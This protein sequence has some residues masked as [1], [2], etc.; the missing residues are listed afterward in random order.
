MNSI[1][2]TLNSSYSVSN[3]IWDIATSCVYSLVGMILLYAT[4]KSLVFLLESTRDIYNE[5]KEVRSITLPFKG[6]IETSTSNIKALTKQMNLVKDANNISVKDILHITTIIT[7]D[8]RLECTIWYYGRKKR[9]V[10]KH[11]GLYSG[12][13]IF[14]GDKHG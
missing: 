3:L 12:L 5:S 7:K 2:G 14:S 4:F 1:I 13:D 8:D 11:H 10:Y 6:Y 9:S